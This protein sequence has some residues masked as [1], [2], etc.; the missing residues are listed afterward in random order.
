MNSCDLCVFV[1]ISLLGM[2]RG[3]AQEPAQN[4]R[5]DLTWPVAVDELLTR[6]AEENKRRENLLV[7]YSSLRTYQAENGFTHSEAKMDVKA[8]FQSS[9]GKEFRII[10]E[11]GSKI[12]RGKVFKPALNAEKEATQPQ[13][14]QR[15]AINKDN[16]DFSFAGEQEL[17]DRRCYVLNLQPRRKE[18]FLL[19]GRV[20]I[21][22]EDYAIARLEGELVKLPSF[23]TRKVEYRRD[24]QKVGEVWLPLKDESVSQLFIFGRSTLSI[25]YSDYQVQ[26][27][28]S[29]KTAEPAHSRA[30]EPP[31]R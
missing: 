6:L 25:T 14:K 29:P 4:H 23:W 5:L 19:R 30:P 20:W 3:S 10:R 31:N 1:V 15:S 28:E 12:I 17:R 26:V 8:T 13:M 11:N 27:R 2:T 24:Y 7:G 16:Y 18:K 21:D 22:S 9:A